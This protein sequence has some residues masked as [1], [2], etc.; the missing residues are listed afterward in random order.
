MSTYHHYKISTGQ[1]THEGFSLK[2][3][4]IHTRLP[5]IRCDIFCQVAHYAD[6]GYMEDQPY[7]TFSGK[8][9]NDNDDKVSTTSPSHHTEKNKLLA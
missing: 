1:M 6:E 8:G 7:M 3:N 4:I 9:T 2:F 5:Y